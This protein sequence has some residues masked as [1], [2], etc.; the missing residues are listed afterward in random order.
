M[1]FGICEFL[2]VMWNSRLLRTLLLRACS[3]G[4]KSGCFLLNLVATEW[5]DTENSWI[6]FSF[7]FILIFWSMSEGQEFAV[8]GHYSVGHFQ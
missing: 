8:T 1:D 6:C 3:A 7:E 4:F 5:I 2:G